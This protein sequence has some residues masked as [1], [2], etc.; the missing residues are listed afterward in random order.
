MT[1]ADT[2]A[3]YQAALRA[4]KYENT[5]D[6]PNTA[7]RTVS[8][9]VN[10]GDLNSNTVTRNI[11][12]T[13]TNDAP[14]LNIENTALEYSFSSGEAKVISESLIVSDPDDTNIESA[15]VQITGNYQNGEDVLEFTDT[16]SITGT[17]NV[18]TGTLT[19]TGADTV[20]NYQA[21]LRTVTYTDISTTAN[22]FQR[23]ITFT[24]NDGDSNS[25]PGTR[26]I[27]TV[28]ENNNDGTEED[29]PPNGVDDGTSNNGILDHSGDNGRDGQSGENQNRDQ[30]QNGN[31]IF[32]IVENFR[33][34]GVFSVVNDFSNR[35]NYRA[36]DN[37][38]S[39]GRL[40]LSNMLDDSSAPQQ[41]QEP[42]NNGM[43]NGESGMMGDTLFNLP[44]GEALLDDS[45]EMQDEEE[46]AMF[47]GDS[48]CSRFADIGTVFEKHRL[49]KTDYE[50][51]LDELIAV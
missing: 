21:A 24:V 36:V 37:F 47:L 33:S 42:L 27:E 11:D 29:V 50:K 25:T 17:W 45:S 14:C 48:D 26:T 4:V 22:T 28:I 49:F 7:Q 1:G 2:L 51:A 44:D 30:H 13:P 18:A 20:A 39:Q 40:D 9:R 6:A 34:N 32:N 10:D 31:G 46:F 16:G 3:N 23:T 43:P 5:S 8:F 38:A 19:L 41:Q 35:G 15:T 12:I